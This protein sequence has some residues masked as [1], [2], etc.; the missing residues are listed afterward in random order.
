MLYGPASLAVIRVFGVNKMFGVHDETYAELEAY[1]VRNKVL[2]RVIRQF[3]DEANWSDKV[4]CLQWMG[5]RHAIEYAKE[6]L[7]AGNIGE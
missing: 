4:G 1:K 7:A 6:M 2:E 5:K 3:A